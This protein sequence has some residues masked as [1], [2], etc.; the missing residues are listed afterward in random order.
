MLSR[1]LYRVAGWLAGRQARGREMRR[2]C[3]MWMGGFRSGPRE[4]FE[5]FEGFVTMTVMAMAMAMMT[6]SF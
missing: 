5:D 4:D 6:V 2:G 1:F 3:A